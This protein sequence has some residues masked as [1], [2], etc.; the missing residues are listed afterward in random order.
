MTLPPGDIVLEARDLDL[1]YG[2]RTI[3]AGAGL[4]VRAGDCWF[5]LGPNGE[6][7]TT[8][9]K[10]I[11]GLL[12]PRRGELRLH[13]ALGSRE[14]IGFVPQRGEPNPTLPTTVREF[15]T[16][17]LVGVAAGRAE[18]AER[19][20]WALTR[21]GLAGM[22]GRDY[23]S[24]SGGQRQRALV[25]RA[26]VRRPDLLILDEPT[27]GLDLA[28]EAALLHFL[29]ALN[30]E[31]GLTLICVTHDVAVVARY[32]THVA[33]FSGGTVTAGTPEEVLNRKHLEMVYGVPVEVT[34]TATGS[35]AFQVTLPEGP[36]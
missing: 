27:N 3:L 35:L 8:M 10:A 17:G 23:W 15:V 9:I 11:L 26:L 33:I 32:A 29:A 19:L 18:Q 2:R 30:R 6:G 31:D 5:F 12:R 34:R 36:P 14:R 4:V 13:P 7:K 25:A 22:A 24:L 1:A 20:E 21:A 16:L 28:T